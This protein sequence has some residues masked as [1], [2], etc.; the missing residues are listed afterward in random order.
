MRRE[1]QLT[2]QHIGIKFLKNDYFQGSPSL[3]EQLIEKIEIQGEKMKKLITVKYKTQQKKKNYLQ[4]V[5][6]EINK[7]RDSLT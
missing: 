2:L 3:P 5:A 4:S 6:V 1:I 7:P